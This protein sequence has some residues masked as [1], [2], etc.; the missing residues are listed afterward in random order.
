MK[1]LTPRRWP[2][3]LLATAITVPLSG[4]NSRVADLARTVQ[5]GDQCDQVLRR[6]ETPDY[7]TTKSY[8]GVSVS[9][10]AWYLPP[11]TKFEIGCAAG[12]V[13]QKRFVSMTMLDGKPPTSLSLH[14]GS[15]QLENERNA[16]A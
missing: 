12:F 4:C 8:I 3:I 1:S 11:A 6:L 5:Y 10:H 15:T 9:E 2:T 7:S 13:V 14:D 16:N